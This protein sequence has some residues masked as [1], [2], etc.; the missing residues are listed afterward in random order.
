MAVT[1][2]IF[3]DLTTLETWTMNVNPREGGAPSYK[4]NI[5]Y[6][7]TAGTDGNVLAFE[8]RDEAQTS[9]FSGVILTETMYNTLYTWFNKRHQIQVTDD[10]GREFV[11]YITSFDAKRKWSTSHPWRHDYTMT[12]TIINWV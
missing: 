10:L 1:R 6:Q 4:K 2:W 12:Y 3:D 8:G 7:N 9:E 11:I 5:S